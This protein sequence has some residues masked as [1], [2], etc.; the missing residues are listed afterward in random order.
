MFGFIHLY[1]LQDR[2]ENYVLHSVEWQS[3]FSQDTIDKLCLRIS[4]LEVQVK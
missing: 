2:S 3:Q 1:V 4:Y